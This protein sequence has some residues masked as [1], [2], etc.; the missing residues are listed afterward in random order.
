[1]ASEFDR[2]LMP[3]FM[4][5][6]LA[7]SLGCAYRSIEMMKDPPAALTRMVSEIKTLVTPPP[8]DGI[9]DVAKSMASLWLKRGSAYIEE[10]RVTGEKFTE[11]R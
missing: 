10:C 9:A 3:G 2:N 1:M 11:E 8:G 7:I 5:T 6:S 4:R